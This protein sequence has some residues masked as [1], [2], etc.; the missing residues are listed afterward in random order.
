MDSGPSRKP[1]ERHHLLRLSRPFWYGQTDLAESSRRHLLDLTASNAPFSEAMA[2]NALDVGPLLEPLEI[3]SP[4]L[5]PDHPGRI[6][7]KPIRCAPFRRC[8]CIYALATGVHNTNT[9]QRSAPC[10]R[11]RMPRPRR[12]ARWWRPSISS[13]CSAFATSTLKESQD[14]RA[15]T[16][17]D[18]EQLNELDRRILKE[19]SA[20]QRKLQEPAQARLSGEL[21]DARSPEV[22]LSVA[23]TYRPTSIRRWPASR[24]MAALQPPIWTRFFS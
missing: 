21:I 9:V 1:A 4:D 14:A 20:R 2:H 7:L 12:S 18:P 19:S 6:D 10:R 8:G 17:I 15:T 23:I 11:G 24:A 5:D 16:A 3:S 22:P 13:N